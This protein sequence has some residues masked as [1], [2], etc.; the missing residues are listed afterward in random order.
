MEGYITDKG[1]SE[2]SMR[3]IFYL[4]FKHKKKIFFFFITVS[5][6]SYF[7]VKSIPDVYQSEASLLITAGR[8]NVEMIP[9]AREAV[10][11]SRT[12]DLQTEVEI[13]RN[14]DVIEEVVDKIGINNFIDEKKVT[15]IDI[16]SEDANI[17]IRESIILSLMGNISLNIKRGTSIIGITYKSQKPQLA[18]NVIDT[19]IY[20]YLDKR[21]DIHFSSSQYD[22]FKAQVDSSLYSINEIEKKIVEKKNELIVPSDSSD[23]SANLSSRIVLLQHE[24]DQNITTIAE[25]ESKIGYFTEI[26][27]DMPDTVETETIINSENVQ[28]EIYSLYLKKLDLLSKYSEENPRVKEIDRQIDEITKLFSGKNKG[29]E[30]FNSNYQQL[31]QNLNTEKINL[32]S[33]KAKNDALNKISNS[34][35]KGINKN[36][37]SELEISQLE[38]DKNNLIKTY[39]KYLDSLTE[40]EIDK[41]VQKQN[42]SNVKI[43]QSP[44]YP[45]RPLA[46]RKMRNFAL[47][48]FM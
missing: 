2:F 44:T 25:S 32:I 39:N 46:T 8:E 11:I 27:K 9:T 24:I 12:K 43:L 45:V 4:L 5:S 21:I 3:E 33:L 41:T 6:L 42:I 37:D 30:E 15:N 48:V 22:F 47:G 28:S 19:L 14:R 23:Y 36:N 10:S 7:Y 29:N 16:I 13:L 38:R 40:A 35:K 17:Q 26:L 1:F 31:L 34:L 20:V 18:K